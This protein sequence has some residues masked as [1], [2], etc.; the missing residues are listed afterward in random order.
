MDCCLGL[1]CWNLRLPMRGNSDKVPGC[2]ESEGNEDEEVRE[3]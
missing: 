3:L 1:D 2:G